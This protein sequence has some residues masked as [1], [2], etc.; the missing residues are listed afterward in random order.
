MSR[1]A[2]ARVSRWTTETGKPISRETAARW[3]ARVEFGKFYRIA[4]PLPKSLQR[5][6]G[7]HRALLRGR[8]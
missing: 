4:A 3:L 5:T 7:E 2:P 8:R 6:P 1:T